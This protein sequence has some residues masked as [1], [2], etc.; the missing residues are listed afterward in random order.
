MSDKLKPCPFCG[1]HAIID[2]CDDTLWIVICKECNAS[3]GYKETK[4]EA[5]EEWN[6]RVQPTFTFREL[7]AIY[8]VFTAPNP[9][10]FLTDGYHSIVEKCELALKG[11]NNE[12]H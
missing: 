12:K 3:I 6:R 11:G 8:E 9:S 5:I 10:R 1:G 2:G 4:E 7:Y